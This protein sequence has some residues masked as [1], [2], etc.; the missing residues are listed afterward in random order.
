MPR[1][2]RP[3]P[4]HRQRRLRRGVRPVRPAHR[5]RVGDRDRAIEHRR[6]VARRVDHAHRPAD[7]RRRSRAWCRT[8]RPRS[9]SPCTAARTETP[10]ARRSSRR[11]RDSARRCRRRPCAA[12][13]GRR[14]EHRL[15]HARRRVAS[16][17]TPRRSCRAPWAPWSSSPRDVRRGR[18]VGLFEDDVGGV[19]VHGR[20]VAVC[21]AFAGFHSHLTPVT[22]RK[23]Q[24]R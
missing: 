22:H 20:G 19:E 16:R 6:A 2:L 17:R 13:P 23:R 12:P 21:V 7:A 14:R 1:L 8:A 15:V 9:R 24:S 18:A 11:R 5:R 4:A 3:D 10:A